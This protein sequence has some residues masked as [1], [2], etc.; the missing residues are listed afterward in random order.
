MNVTICGGGSLGLAYAALMGNNVAP[1]LY[2]R[3]EAQAEKI[4]ELGVTASILGVNSHSS[5]QASSSTDVIADADLVICLVKYPDTTSL[6]DVLQS[7]LSPAA[8]IISLQTGIR[9]LLEYQ[10]ALGQERVVG[11]VSYLGAKRTSETSVELGKNLRTVL[12]LDGVTEEHAARAR[13]FAGLAAQSDLEFELS[14]NIRLVIWQKLVIACSQ[15]AVSALTGATF[16]QL[17][18]TAEWYQVLRD[19]I[20]EVVAVAQA[21]GI[22]LPDGQLDRV[23]ANWES[24]PDH[25]ASTYTDLQMSRLTEIDALNGSVVELGR[26]HDIRVPLN[27]LLTCMTHMAEQ[28]KVPR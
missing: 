13:S 2:V 9:P 24:L 14:D 18:E 1:R 17:R 6:R 25:R 27:E 26:Q 15:N 19:L 12:G 8:T 21:E 10:S 3:K 5:I 4:N 20:G 28:A 22:D 7:A 23:F 11:G 16:R